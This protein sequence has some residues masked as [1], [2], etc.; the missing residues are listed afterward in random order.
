MVSHILKQLPTMKNIIST[1]VLLIYFQLSAAQEN[2]KYNHILITN[3]DGIEDTD[4]LFA[5]ATCVKSVSKRVSIV[6]STFDRS[7]TSNHTTYGKHQSTLQITCKY[8]DKEKNIGFYVIPGN[9]G[10]CVV[11]GLNGLFS[12][13]KPDLVLSGING[14]ANIGP[15]WFGSGTIG[16]IRMSA[17]LG[18]RGI[19]LSGFDDGDERSFK[20]IPQWVTQFISSEI[21]D[22]IDKNSY[23]TIGFPDIPLEEIKGVKV[24]D[25]RISFDQPESVVVYKI[26]GD[27]PHKSENTTVWALKFA[28]NLYDA[29]VTYDDTYL[30]EGYIVITPMSINE[31]DTELIGTFQERIA[32]I[33]DFSLTNK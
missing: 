24:A 27:D 3:D 6:V 8:F 4:R 16:A 2:F 10:D 18:V 29:A 21:I 7:G 12:D 22:E 31:N 23:L 14:G 11:L 19:A 9:P 20:V 25:R 5:L 15:G 1:L 13:D 33:P 17:F 32:Q 28:D 26:L 30:N